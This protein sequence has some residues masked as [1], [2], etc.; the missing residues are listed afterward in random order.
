MKNPIT[1]FFVTLLIFFSLSITYGEEKTLGEVIISGTS[2]SGTSVDPKALSGITSNIKDTKVILD[3]QESLLKNQINDLEKQNADLNVKIKTSQSESKE[4][5]KLKDDLASEVEKNKEVINEYKKQVLLI[6]ELKTQNQELSSQIEK[7]KLGMSKQ[8]II[9]YFVVGFL[10]LLYIGAFFLK[11]HIRKKLKTN[12]IKLEN[13][14]NPLAFEYYEKMQV[15]NIIYAIVGIGLFI[16]IIFYYNR[17]LF[18]YLL[19]AFGAIIVMLKDFILNFFGFLIILFSRYRVGDFIKIGNLAGEVI[20]ID[21]MHAT[22]IGKSENGE[23]IGEVH[24][25]PNNKFFTDIISKK[26]SYESAVFLQSLTI[27]YKKELY[28]ISLD[29]FL[30]KIKGFLDKKIHKNTPTTVG[31]YK[32]FIGYKYKIDLQTDGDPDKILIIIKWIQDNKDVTKYKTSVF[33]FVEE[34]KQNKY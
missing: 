18:G 24:K 34:M 31:Y 5:L 16:G 12:Y 3:K 27:I 28:N 21:M 2:Q 6:E 14:N 8:E 30:E 9:S 29:E 15:I 4:Y 25:I 13:E 19:I 7:S 17:G 1:I 32:S 20:F 23:Y 10:I 11:N 22:I 26:G 33:D